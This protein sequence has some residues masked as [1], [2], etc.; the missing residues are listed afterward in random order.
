MPTILMGQDLEKFLVSISADSTPNFAYGT[1]KGTTIINSQSV[2]VPGNKD[3]HFIISHRFG[4]INTGLYNFFGLDQGTTRLGL[5]Y[6]IKDIVGLSLG[7]SSY[8]KTYDG[9]I[10]VR[11]LRQQTGIKEIPLSISIYSAIFVETIKWDVPEREN[12]FSSRLS[13]AT[14]LMI[15]RK[16]GKRLSLQ[17][18]PSY[19]HF[20]LVPTEEDQNN[21]FSV[22]AGGR[23]KIGN[24]FSVN[25]EYFYLLPG[26]T[27]KKYSNSFSLGCDIETGG[28]VFQL[29]FTNSQMI[30][31]PGYIARTEG[32]WLDGDIYIGFN[33]FRVFPLN[34][35]D[36]KK[37]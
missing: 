37:N 19:V 30:F 36:K 13:Y 20:N 16:F 1:F 31:A 28:H 6:G 14:E 23:Y 3:F 25:G 7:R 26:E 10:K 22:G 12:L 8:N 21:V 4:A 34:K 35:K 27:A 2:E 9:G 5:E 24:K 32:E 29:H 11:V 33:I 18:T 15:A 17:L